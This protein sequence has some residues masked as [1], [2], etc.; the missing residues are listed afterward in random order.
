MKDYTNQIIEHIEKDNYHA[1]TEIIEFIKSQNSDGYFI[2]NFIIRHLIQEKIDTKYLKYIIDN[3]EKNTIISLVEFILDDCFNY[4]NSESFKLIT[5]F[6]F[7]KEVIL[8][9]FKSEINLNLA[10]SLHLKEYDIGIIECCVE[11]YSNVIDVEC[12]QHRFI[13]SVIDKLYDNYPGSYDA[14]DT[15]L[16]NILNE[17]IFNEKFNFNLK[18]GLKLLL[19]KEYRNNYKKYKKN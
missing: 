11:K 15:G 1:F 18:I 17:L 9:Y 13:L 14:L 6:N 8:K 16:K 3:S 10:N 5:S 4:N 19:D 7:I 2:M 12:S